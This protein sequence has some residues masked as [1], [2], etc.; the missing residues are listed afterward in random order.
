MLNR[1]PTLDPNLSTTMNYRRTLRT[2]GLSHQLT[3]DYVYAM[4]EVMKAFETAESNSSLELQTTI[5]QV[6]VHRENC[7]VF[8][9]M[10]EENSRNHPSVTVIK[11]LFLNDLIQQFQ[12]LEEGRQ[13]LEEHVL[14]ADSYIG[15]KNNMYKSPFVFKSDALSS[16][17]A[18]Q[19]K[20]LMTKGL[21]HHITSMMAY[22]SPNLKGIETISSKI[23]E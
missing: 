19:T 3:H 5:S 8:L 21:P 1:Y 17:S 13:L 18:F 16:Q 23:V 14:N 22:D 15:P 20:L 10:M 11:G 6:A 9:Q 12:N 4:I 7:L 2:M